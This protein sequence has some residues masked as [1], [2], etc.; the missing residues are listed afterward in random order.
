M[1]TRNASVGAYAPTQYSKFPGFFGLSV[2]LVY[3]IFRFNEHVGL[4]LDR[5][6]HSCANLRVSL[7]VRTAQ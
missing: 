4:V 6:R 5:V 2:S 3:R 7:S 1:N